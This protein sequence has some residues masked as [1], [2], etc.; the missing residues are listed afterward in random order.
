[1]RN[2]KDL[3]KADNPDS[4]LRRAI[5]PSGGWVYHRKHLFNSGRWRSYREE[6]NAWLEKNLLPTEELVLVGS[7]AGYNLSDG[8][9]FEFPRLTSVEIDPLAPFF[10]SR[11][12]RLPVQRWVTQNF[13]GELQSRKIDPLAFQHL[14]QF[15]PEAPL[16]FCN[17]LGQLGF[18]YDIDASAA[19]KL[20]GE[21]ENLKRPWASFHDVFSLH[22]PSR[23]LERFQDSFTRPKS[24]ADLV[25]SLMA[26]Q[27]KIEV[28]DHWTMDIVP[29]SK[30]AAYFLWPLTKNSLHVVEAVSFG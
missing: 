5:Q 17:L 14:R 24:R 22:G 12:H 11:K 30:S 28:R 25:K 20:K 7:S 9:L 2:P 19:A 27:V 6:L 29:E 4:W 1:M 21:L 16:L 18:L 10:W 8:F 13:F 26:W 3:K 15:F 23:D